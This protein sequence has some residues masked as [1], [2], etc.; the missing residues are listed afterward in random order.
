MR[1]GTC[2]KPRPSGKELPDRHLEP[3]V[4]ALPA[5]LHGILDRLLA[6]I[7]SFAAFHLF[8]HRPRSQYRKNPG[9]RS[10][11]RNFVHYADWISDKA[12]ARISRSGDRDVGVESGLDYLNCAS[13]G[14]DGRRH[15]R[16]GSNWRDYSATSLLRLRFPSRTARA[17]RNVY[18]IR[19]S[20]AWHR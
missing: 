4:H 10:Y 12:P 1:D 11:R 19:L 8:L 17:A 2:D 20:A 3:A 7:H 18:G 13:R 9:Y 6:G 16:R 15:T 5:D 14:V